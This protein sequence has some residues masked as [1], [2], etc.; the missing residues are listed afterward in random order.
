MDR[1]Q[2]AVQ[3]MLAALDAPAYDLGVRSERGMLPGLANLSANGVLARDSPPEGPQCA[4][5]AHL[6]PASR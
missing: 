4:G 2:N 1:T 6:Y 3:R 5:R